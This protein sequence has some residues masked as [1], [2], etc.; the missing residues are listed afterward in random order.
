MNPTSVGIARHSR[1]STAADDV[2]V[3]GTSVSHG[4]VRMDNA[5]MSR[6]AAVLPLGTLVDIVPS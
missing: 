3:L 6:L 5:E 4:S 1:P 2:T